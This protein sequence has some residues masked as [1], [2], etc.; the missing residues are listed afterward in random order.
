MR[1]GTKATRFISLKHTTNVEDVRAIA[2]RRLPMAVKDFIEGGAEDEI[3]LRRN[4]EDF[5]ALSFAPKI[6]SSTE[7]RDQSTTLMGTPVSSPLVL[8]PVGLAALAHPEGERAAAIA[9]A[10]RGLISTLSASSC[11]DLEEV[12]A[13]VPDA[14]RWFQ[15][16]VW[17]D[18]GITREVVERARA[19]GYRVLA[20]TADVQVAARRERDLRNGFEIPPRPTLRQGTDVVRHARWFSRMAWD[21]VFG[22]GLRMGNFVKKSRI[23]TRISMMQQVNTLFDPQLRWED[24]EWFKEL[25]GGPVLVKGITTSADAAEAVRRGADGIWVSNHGGRQ[26][27]GLPST[28]SVLPEIVDAVGDRA[29]VILDSG[30]RRGSDVVKA[31]ALGATA[32]VIGR[33]YVYGLAAGGQAG[34]ERVIDLLKAEIDA[35]LALIGAASIHDLDRS[36]LRSPTVAWETVA[37]T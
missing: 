16:Y 7:E 26:L 28:I 23:G 2:T 22:H 3:T 21:E 20:L 1:D 30:V 6:L 13:A 14:P 27:D 4:R 29:D 10:N 34:V 12:A 24:L 19:A 33:P 17:R 11:W 36:F 18:R 31:L 5:Q 8:A 32:A 9:A 37:R 15:L 35:T 25:W